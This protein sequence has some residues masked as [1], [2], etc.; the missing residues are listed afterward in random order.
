LRGS[1]IFGGHDARVFRCTNEHRWNRTR[2]QTLWGICQLPMDR[3]QEAGT[4][5]PT[6]RIEDRIDMFEPRQ[7]AVHAV[8][9]ERVQRFSEEKQR[10]RQLLVALALLLH[11]DSSGLGVPW[12]S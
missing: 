9:Q 8:E 2:P 10:T 3:V 7:I 5:L 1:R 11:G 4:I 12:A 6:S